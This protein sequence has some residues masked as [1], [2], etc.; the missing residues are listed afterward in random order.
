MN[1]PRILQKVSSD[2]QEDMNEFADIA[3]TYDWTEQSTADIPFFVD[4]ARQAESPILEVGA[5]TGRITIPIAELGKRVVALD[6]SESM[7]S[8]A[9]AK[10]NADNV[11][12][13][14]GDF[15]SLALDET[16]GLILAPGR[17]FEHALSDSDRREAFRRCSSHLKSSGLLA[18]YVWGP[19][20]DAETAPPEKSKMIDPTDEHGTLRFSW[21][22]ARDF[23]RELRT[24][25]F[26]VEELNGQMR[27]WEHDPI[28][29]RWYRPEV[30]D[31]LGQSVG[32]RTLDRYQDFQKTPYS[33]GSLHMI[34]VYEKR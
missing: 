32:L 21:R 34:W 33:D 1:N 17:T 16:F 8:R 15:Q 6:I 27:T 13:L 2:V 26:R 20:G 25:H 30:L 12:F 11:S 19:P 4:L 23:G 29:I 3:E 24:H 10:T 31:E 5:G 28:E 22:E 9:K 7:L 18:L 14:I